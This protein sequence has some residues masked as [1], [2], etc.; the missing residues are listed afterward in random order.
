M[1]LLARKEREAKELAEAREAP[2]EQERMGR[3]SG[4][5]EWRDA[6][7]ESGDTSTGVSVAEAR[8]IVFAFDSF[9]N[10]ESQFLRN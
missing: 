2:T 6:R 1:L 7:G 8:D 10:P 9:L 4:S 5:K 3:E